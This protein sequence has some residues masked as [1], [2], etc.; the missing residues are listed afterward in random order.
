MLALMAGAPSSP[1]APPPTAMD[2]D[3]DPAPHTSPM[4]TLESSPRRITRSMLHKL[5]SP[6][7]PAATTAAD[8]AKEVAEPLLESE[9]QRR[10]TRSLLLKN[11]K[12]D[13]SN[14]DDDLSGTTT[15]SNS[16]SPSTTSINKGTSILH[17]NKIPTNLKELLSTGLLEDQLAWI[18]LLMKTG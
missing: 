2:A 12:A 1:L 6:P 4:E 11:N 16:F 7:P 13:H 18:H 14:N 15:A 10:F 5:H 3:T 17:A 8:N 9:G